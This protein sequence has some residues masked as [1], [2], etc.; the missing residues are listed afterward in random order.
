MKQV[1]LALL[2]AGVVAA[3]VHWGTFVA[4]GSDSFCYAHQA[5]RWASGRL[6]VVEPLALEAPWPEPPLAFA[7]AGHVP[8]PTVHGALVPICPAGL[9]LAMAPFRWLGG[10]D[11][12]FLV[13]PLFGALL[14]GATFV[15]GARYGARV[16]LAAAAIVACSPVFLYQLV[17]PMSDVPAAALWMAAVA[18]ATGTKARA[19][20]VAGGGRRRGDPDA[21]QPRAARRADRAVPAVPSRA[22]MA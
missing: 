21:A 12:I 17:Q 19:P 22:G 5:E 11:A 13:V 16:G 6:Q 14:I 1:A 4:G 8:S 20:L 15:A 7:P 9:S 3:G 10:R 18:A 2:L